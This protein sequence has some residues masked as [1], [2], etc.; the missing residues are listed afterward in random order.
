MSKRSSDQVI[1][2]PAAGF[3]R[4]V[5]APLA[6]E[7]LPRPLGSFFAGRPL[8]EPSLYLAEHNNCLAHIITRENKCNL[9]HWINNCEYKNTQIQ[10]VE[11]TKEWPETILQSERF[12]K[13]R[14]IVLLPDVDFSPTNILSHIFESLNSYDTAWA[15]FIP[16]DYNLQTWGA[17]TEREKGIYHCEKPD[18]W[19]ENAKAWGV[20]GFRKNCGRQ[21]LQQ[22]LESSFD[23]QWRQIPGRSYLCNLEYFK[24]LTRAEVYSCSTPT[25]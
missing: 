20:F 23:H 12:W 19:D 13:E 9:V 25:A 11:P 3:G 10:F 4:R 7:L 17:I 18:S 14:N 5:G 1:I 2:I 16:H 22:L 15:T 6:K 8:I 21:L 24:D